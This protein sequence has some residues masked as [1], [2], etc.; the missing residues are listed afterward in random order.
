MAHAWVSDWLAF[1][2]R[3]LLPQ[4]IDA[5]SVFS[6]KS[7]LTTMLWHACWCNH[8]VLC[9]VITIGQ[10]TVLRKVRHING[11]P[12]WLSALKLEK[13]GL[14]IVASNQKQQQPFE[15]YG[16]RRAIE[17]LFQALKGRGFNREDTR[18]E[19]GGDEVLEYRTDCQFM[20][21]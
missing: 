12:V 15:I 13:G 11:Q 16:K 1:L 17:T 14:L 8:S 6:V 7:T 21:D 19:G 2:Q 18:L 9:K 5:C 10:S 20:R 4:G 3:E